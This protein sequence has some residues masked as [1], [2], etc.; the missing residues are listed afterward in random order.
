VECG[1]KLHGGFDADGHYLSP[2]TRYRWDAINN[3]HKQLDDRGAPIVGASSGLLTEPNFPN[4]SQQVL[5]LKHGIA[6]SFWDSLTITGLIEA[7]G[8]ALAEV[9][10]P[11]FQ[12]VIIE[13]ISATA[14]AHG[15]KGLLS[16]HGWD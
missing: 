5:L 7:C 10:A 13:D 15:N 3:W 9:Q 1:L 16:T 12:A 4:V 6:Q 14:L 8:K 11:G 2:R